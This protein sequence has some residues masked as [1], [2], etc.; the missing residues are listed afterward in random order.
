VDSLKWWLPSVRRFRPPASPCARAAAPCSVRKS[1]APCGPVA[2][3]VRRTV[4]EMHPPDGR[5]SAH[6][7]RAACPKRAVVPEAG[8]AQAP[9]GRQ[10]AMGEAA[11]PPA[12][13][14]RPTH[15]QAALPGTRNRDSPRHAARCRRSACP[16][17]GRGRAR[18]ASRTPSLSARS[19]RL[20]EVRSIDLICSA[21]GG[22]VCR[23]RTAPAA[24]ESSS[25]ARPAWARRTAP[26]SVASRLHSARRNQRALPFGSRTPS[27]T[28]RGA[29]RHDDPNVLPVSHLP[30]GAPYT[31]V[32]P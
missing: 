22:V 10:P 1:M 21:P 14:A 19:D 27:D 28:G 4:H 30:W 25:I 6:P 31:G 32:N 13:S 26:A 15:D 29:L 9:A 24:C 3:Q 8:S 7:G 11:L 5:P 18:C 17:P 16:Q 12:P 23:S 2:V 20:I